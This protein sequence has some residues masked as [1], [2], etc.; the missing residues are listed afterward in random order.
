MLC[1]VVGVAAGADVDQV[2]EI[3]DA[4]DDPLCA[5]QVFGVQYPAKETAENKIEIITSFI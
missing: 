4:D 1:P 5:A 3:L 2:Q